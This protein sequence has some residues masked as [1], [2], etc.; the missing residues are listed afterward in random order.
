MGQITIEIRCLIVGAKNRVFQFDHQKMNMFE[1]IRYKKD[2]R[3]LLICELANQVKALI[4]F[5]LQCLFV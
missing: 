5:D 3:V 1:S 2:V 4:R